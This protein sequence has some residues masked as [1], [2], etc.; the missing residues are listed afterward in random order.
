MFSRTS[1]TASQKKH[2]EDA[3]KRAE[4]K[5]RNAQIEDFLHPA[6]PS[7]SIARPSP[8]FSAVDDGRD[9][10]ELHEISSINR[11]DFMFAQLIRIGN[12]LR[13]IKGT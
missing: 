1:R 10:R 7:P 12:R 3:R 2:V 8:V 13:I 5:D 6:R 9:D 4:D 11:T